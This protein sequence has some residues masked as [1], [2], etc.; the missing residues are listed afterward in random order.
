MITPINNNTLKGVLI[1]VKSSDLNKVKSGSLLNTWY[2]V[3]PDT[4]T[5]GGWLGVIVEVSYYEKLKEQKD[6]L[7]SMTK[8]LLL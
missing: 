7:S 6:L 2:T 5:H 3:V 1:Y 8:D 4:F